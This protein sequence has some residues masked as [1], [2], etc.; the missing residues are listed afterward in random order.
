MGVTGTTVFTG[1]TIRT[2]VYGNTVFTGVALTSRR[3]LP[4][5]RCCS[6]WKCAAGA[7]GKWDDTTGRTPY[8]AGFTPEQDSDELIENQ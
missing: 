5:T 2:V 4:L 7:E 3:A 8:V 1:V 6:V